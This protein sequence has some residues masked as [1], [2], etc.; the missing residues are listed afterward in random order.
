MSKRAFTIQRIVMGS[1]MTALYLGLSMLLTIP[2]GPLKIT[3]EALPVVIC[4]VIFGPLDAAIVGL[5][6][7][8]LNQLLTYGITPTTALW[9]LPSVVRGLMVGFALM[10]LR[11]S[12]AL[13]AKKPTAVSL[14]VFFGVNLISA[15]VVSVLNTLTLYVDSKMFG[16]YSD[17]L[18]FGSLALRI[19]T[20]LA[21]TT[22][23][24]VLTL[25]IV[26][27]LKRARLVR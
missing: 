22:G 15:V 27:A 7:E 17:A 20:G 26:A 21:A 11:K 3:I 18:V 4:A 19:V 10:P 12:G 13:L 8:F 23:M 14:A 24:A 5:L 9:V 2:L 25:P 16:Y 1:L 6:G